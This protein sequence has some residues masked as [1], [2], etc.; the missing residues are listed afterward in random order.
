LTAETVLTGFVLAFT[1]LM[2]YSAIKSKAR[3][4]PLWMPI[5][6]CASSLGRFRARHRA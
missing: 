3:S 5:R 2:P 6:A 4:E 1:P